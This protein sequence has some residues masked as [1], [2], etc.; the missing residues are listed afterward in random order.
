MEYGPRRGASRRASGRRRVVPLEIRDRDGCLRDGRGGDLDRRADAV[1]DDGPLAEHRA[2]FDGQV[3]QAGAVELVGLLVAVD[4]GAALDRHAAA[5]RVDPPVRIGP[6]GGHVQMHDDGVARPPGTAENVIARQ[7]PSS[8]GIIAH[9]DAGAGTPGRHTEGQA[10]PGWRGREHAQVDRAGPRVVGGDLEVEVR[11]GQPGPGVLMDVQ[12]AT[13]FRGEVVIQGGDEAHDVRRAA[14]AVE[15]DPP[16]AG[17]VLLEVILAALQR[18]HVEEPLAP[19]GDRGREAVVEHALHVVRVPGVAGGEQQPPAPL[20]AG[21]GG[22]GLVVGAVRG[23]LEPV[24]N[25][26]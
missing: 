1:Q 10:A 25:V 9:G 13:G 5:H 26:G 23:Q 8:F 20:E 3:V 18:V 14:G 17:V 11:P 21:D 24:G 16:P 12:G 2:R 15:P 19:G 6:A 22:A 4:E 7:D